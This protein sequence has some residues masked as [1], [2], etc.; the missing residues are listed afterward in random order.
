MMLPSRSNGVTSG[1]I[2]PVIRE[3]L[4]RTVGDAWLSHSNEAL[5]EKLISGETRVSS[6]KE[7]D[8]K[9][10][11]IRHGGVFDLA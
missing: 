4:E 7:P 10:C 6:S 9:D 11:H 3:A 8:P 1:G 2:T 5:M